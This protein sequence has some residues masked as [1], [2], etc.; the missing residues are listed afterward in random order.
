[1]TSMELL[2]AIGEVDEAL[3]ARAHTGRPALRRRLTR[4]MVAAACLA[5]IVTGSVWAALRLGYFSSACGANP[6]TFVDGAYYY[7]VRHSGVWRWTE[8]RGNEK[9][10]SAFWENGWLVNENG[11]YYC[12]GRSLYR[13]D[14]E[15]KKRVRLYTAS[16]S[17]SSHIGFDL[18]DDGNPIVTV[19]N[20]R[21]KELFQYRLDGETGE[22]LEPLWGVR[23]KDLENR[24]TATHYQVGERRLTLVKTVEE[25]NTVRYDL[26]EN[27]V[28][29][30]PEGTGCSYY[31]Q[32]LG[33]SLAFWLYPLDGSGDEE[34]TPERLLVRPEGGDMLLESSAP[35]FLDGFGDW[36]FYV[37]GGNDSSP[38][39]EVWCY[40]VM[41]G[42]SW[43]LESDTPWEYYSLT[44][45]GKL[46]FSC[47]PWGEEQTLWRLTYDTMGRPAGLVL[48]EEDIRK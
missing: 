23:Y 33:K 3:A 4:L 25:G 31:P 46:L 12:R 26:R 15:T 2:C 38:A 8:E 18:P 28:S 29:L 10:L 6:G 45:D 34:E 43:K 13:L 5:L 22:V 27:G 32:R 39:D 7:N 19:Y 37:D 41:T 40:D 44:T 24:Y 42:E 17:E 16:A 48:V 1:M 47:V 14:P 21:A 35:G 20:K 9:L 11:L 36:L 30:L